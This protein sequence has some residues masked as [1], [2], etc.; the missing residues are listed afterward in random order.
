MDRLTERPCFLYTCGYGITQFAAI[1]TRTN[2]GSGLDLSISTA[3]RQL[4]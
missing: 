3:H 4:L 2:V 1:G